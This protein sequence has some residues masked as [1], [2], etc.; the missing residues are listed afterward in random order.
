MPGH[1]RQ[2]GI[3]LFGEEIDITEI[4]GFDN[5][6]SP[7]GIIKA[8]QEKLAGLY[9]CRKSI[10]SVN[11]STCGILAAVSAVSS[12][13]DDIIVAANC[14]KS[15][16]N[17]CLINALNVR[18]VRPE[19]N[20]SFS[21]WGRVS[22]KAVD[23]AVRQY[24]NACAVVITSPTY[25][26]F[27]SEISCPV[28]LIVDAAHGAHF[29]FYGALPS[30]PSADITV[31]SLHKTLPSLTQTALVNINNEKYFSSVKYYMD[32]F[33]TSS[34]SYILL[35]SVCKCA[36]FLEGSSSAFEKLFDM[37][38]DFYYNMRGFDNISFLSNDDAT[39]IIV[40]AD[41]Y[42]GAQ[43][44]DLL[45]NKGI[46][47]EGAALKYVILIST[48]C[49]SERGFNLLTDALTSLERREENIIFLPEP[50]TPEDMFYTEPSADNCET[51]LE[52]CIDEICAEFVYAYPPGSP[53]LVPGQKISAGTVDYIAKLIKSGV[54]VL[55]DSSLLPL[56]ILT[57]RLY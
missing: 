27:V 45:R 48:V 16:F 29:G 30:Q 1:K 28:P 37:L 23:D 10:I 40:R 53:L 44:A 18:F 4:D 24:P 39:R 49:D 33:E 38:N 5:L 21:C 6:H 36:D 54:N 52:E 34:P 32:A 17:A 13:G 7:N 57:K 46:E 3:S 31:V 20:D 15:V 25:E 55:S 51:P 22:Q 11:G 19:Y 47:P 43:L 12:R 2:S 9:A 56:K 50:I 14:H 8:A 42:S 35:D 41:G 26:G